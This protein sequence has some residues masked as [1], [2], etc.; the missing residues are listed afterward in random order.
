MTAELSTRR[1]NRVFCDRVR[2][3]AV[4]ETC[5]VP[6]GISEG[7]LRYTLIGTWRINNYR[8]DASADGLAVT[9]VR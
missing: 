6:D 8:I 2:D 7:N 1:R 5:V 3:M 4:G 9:R